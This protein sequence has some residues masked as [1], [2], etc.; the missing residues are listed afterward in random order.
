MRSRTS[1]GGGYSRQALTLV[2][3]AAILA[4]AA[5]NLRLSRSMGSSLRGGGGRITVRASEGGCRLRHLHLIEE[6]LIVLLYTNP[7]GHCR[8]NLSSVVLGVSP[9]VSTATGAVTP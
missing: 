1:L 9:P 6:A 3:A 5:C 8:P 7:S 4:L 2:A